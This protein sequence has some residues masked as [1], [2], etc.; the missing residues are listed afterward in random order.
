MTKKTLSKED[1]KY[2]G[3]FR[4][5]AK[6]RISGSEFKRLSLIHSE[7]FSH[8][9]YLPCTCNPAGI[10]KFIDDINNVYDL[11]NTNNHIK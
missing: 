8:R 6:D 2:W 3:N 9:Y 7:L 5:N 4:D 10:Q 11:M 1:F